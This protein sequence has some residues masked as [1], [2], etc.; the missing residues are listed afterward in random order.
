MVGIS[1]AGNAQYVIG[2]LDFASELGCETIGITSNEGTLITKHAKI[3]IITD[4][5]AEVVTGS[6]RMKAG[7][8]QKL[9]LNML[10]ILKKRT[11]AKLFL[12]VMSQ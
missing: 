3:S 8:A 9:I 5:G 10:L 11:R 12:I 1:A 2:A 7:T 4:T 6:T